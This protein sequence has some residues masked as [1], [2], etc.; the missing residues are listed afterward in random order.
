MQD[1]GYF[2]QPDPHA[3]Y[4][5]RPGA[6][7]SYFGTPMDT[8]NPDG[9]RGP[10]VRKEHAGCLRIACLGDSSTFGMCVSE[11]LSWP[12]QLEGLLRERRTGK[13]IDVIN[14]GVIGYSVLQGQ[15]KYEAKVRPYNPDFAVLAF[16]AIND[17]MPAGDAP[18]LE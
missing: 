18:D 3:F 1:L 7:Y 2:L 4:D 8:I 13:P 14:A 16:G 6:Q 10:S 15:R 11:A 5:L 12:R 17:Q 9:F